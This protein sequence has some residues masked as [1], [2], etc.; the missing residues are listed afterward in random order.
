MID[1]SQFCPAYAGPR[2]SAASANKTAPPPTYSR[3]SARLPLRVAEREHGRRR[4]LRT[5]LLLRARAVARVDDNVVGEI[6]ALD[7]VLR[8]RARH[9]RVCVASLVVS[10]HLSVCPRAIGA[11]HL[12]IQHAE[13]E[14]A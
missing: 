8:S 12:R 7:K 2:C 14:G 4:V 11:G 6:V 3:K 5:D 1:F 13:R 9:D 10:H